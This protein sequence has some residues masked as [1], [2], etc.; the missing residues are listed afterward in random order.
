MPK[1]INAQVSLITLVMYH[2]PKAPFF[3]QKH[4][5]STLAQLQITVVRCWS[6][7]SFKLPRVTLGNLLFWYTV[8]Y[9]VMN[10]LFNNNF[11]KF[12]FGF[13]AVIVGT[14]LFILVVGSTQ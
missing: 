2:D 7:C 3:T 14:L 5:Q 11:Y 4:F 9:E 13:I 8:T 6:G 10:K 1:I 12:L